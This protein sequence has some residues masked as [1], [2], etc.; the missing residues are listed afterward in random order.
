MN[1]ALVPAPPANLFQ[2]IRKTLQI[3]PAAVTALAVERAQREQKECAAIGWKRSWADVLDWAMTLTMTE[4]SSALDG[5][6]ADRERSGITVTELR[7]RAADLYAT[8]AESAIP[9]R[10]DEAARF[11]AE[12]AALRAPAAFSIAA[13]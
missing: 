6:L 12:A 9:P 5:A 13:E 7:A 11:R 10:K 1:V 2:T 8:L 3:D 4:A